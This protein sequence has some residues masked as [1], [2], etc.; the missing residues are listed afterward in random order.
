L[1]SIWCFFYLAFILGI[2]LLTRVM[3]RRLVA[4]GLES[5]IVYILPCVALWIFGVYYWSHFTFEVFVKYALLL[6]LQLWQHYFENY[7]GHVS[8]A[9]SIFGSSLV[10]WVMRICICS[11]IV[12]VSNWFFGQEI[13]HVVVSFFLFLDR[14]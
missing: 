13:M 5:V 2:S 14:W 1:L 6:L 12:S 7:W 9:T 3:V 10:Y 11:R 4:I 8:A